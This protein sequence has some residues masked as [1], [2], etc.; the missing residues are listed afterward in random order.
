MF[1]DFKTRRGLYFIQKCP[2]PKIL[3]DPTYVWGALVHGASEN[4][5]VR[6]TVRVR[7]NDNKT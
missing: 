5:V 4:K 3:F 1:K 6:P 7:L 2:N